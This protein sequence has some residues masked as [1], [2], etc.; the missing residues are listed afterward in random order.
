MS[1]TASSGATSYNVYQ[2]TTAGSESSTPVATGITATTYTV[3][4]LTNGTPYYFKV[5]GVNS[6]GVSGYSNEASATPAINYGTPVAI[7]VPNYSFELDNESNYIVPQDWTVSASGGYAQDVCSNAGCNLSLTGVTG[8][9][10]WAPYAEGGSS[11]PYGT[12]VITLTSA[13]SLGTFAANTQYGL[14][15]SMA[16]SEP[17]TSAVGM[18]LLANGTVVASFVAPTTGANA[19]SS[20]GFQDYSVT[21]T[22]VGNS[23]VV[24]QN[25]TVALVYT[26]TGPYGRNA[27]FDNI[28]LTQALETGLPPQAPTGLTASAGNGQIALS[29]TASAGAAS[30]KCLP[31]HCVWRGKLNPGGYRRC[32]GQPYRDR[33]DGRNSLL[34]QGRGS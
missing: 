30:H 24:G 10:Y 25:I 19:I 6:A 31:R 7:N 27:Y 34:L 8:T 4:G 15:V 17:L 28:R 1:W 12:E 3:T 20:N 5:K 33:P 18:E 2:G 22:T 13:S 23:S 11:A 16:A 14:T 26:Y 21:F 9:Y 29:W 32:S